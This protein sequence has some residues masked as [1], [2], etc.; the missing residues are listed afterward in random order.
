MCRVCAHVAVSEMPSYEEEVCPEAEHGLAAQNY[1][2]A[3]CLTRTSHS[4]YTLFMARG[5]SVTDIQQRN[6]AHLPTLQY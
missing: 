2:C 1:R 3:E 4:T 5:M 6:F